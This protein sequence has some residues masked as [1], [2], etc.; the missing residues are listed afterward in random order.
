MIFSIDGKTPNIHPTAFVA[1]SAVLIGDV[2]LEENSSVWFGAVLRGDSGKIVIGEGTNVQDGA[3][4][5]E[6]TVLGK[7]CVLAHSV[8]VHKAVLGNRVLIG[9]GALVYGGVNVGDGAIVGAGAVISGPAEIPPNTV[10]VGVPAK[11]VRTTDERLEEMTKRLNDSYIRNRGRYL[12][13]LTPVDDAAKAMMD[14]L[15]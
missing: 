9:H 15:A 11:Q 1:P 6:E 7:F 5:H 2:T 14:R 13:G 12:E 8:L 3:I 4:L 10:W